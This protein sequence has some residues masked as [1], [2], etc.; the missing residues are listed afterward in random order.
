MNAYRLWGMIS[1]SSWLRADGSFLC[2]SFLLP[3][4]KEE[5]T[6]LSLFFSST[7]IFFKKQKNSFYI[8]PAVSP[9]STPP[10][11]PNL[12]SF[13]DPLTA[14]SPHRKEWDSQGHQ[15]NTAK[16][17]IRSGTNPHIEAGQGNLE[18][19]KQ[20]QEQAKSQGHPTSTARSLPQ[21]AHQQP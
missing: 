6:N 21:T 13:S 15:L 9:P 14:P 19:R 5:I 4:E 8:T 12:P 17:T 16:D 11:P 2:S 3:R 1:V 7:L 20:S 10:G 18:G